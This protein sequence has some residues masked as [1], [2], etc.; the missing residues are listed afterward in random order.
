MKV[1]V[2]WGI[3]GRGT[4]NEVEIPAVLQRLSEGLRFVFC[5]HTVVHSD[6]CCLV[7]DPG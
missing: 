1:R 6:F 4:D 2:V 3:Q 7:L 5:L